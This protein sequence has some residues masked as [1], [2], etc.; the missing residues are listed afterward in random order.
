MCVLHLSKNEELHDGLGEHR[1]A[2]IFLYHKIWFNFSITYTKHKVG[3][4]A[5]LIKRG[6]D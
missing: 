3:F 4:Y 5:S 6:G 2:A 1:Y